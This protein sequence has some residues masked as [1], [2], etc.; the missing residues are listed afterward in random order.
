MTLFTH[1]FIRPIGPAARLGGPAAGTG[2]FGEALAVT[3]LAGGGFAIAWAHRPEGGAQGIWMRV[4]GEDGTPEGP[5]RQI[6]R[7]LTDPGGTPL[8][9]NA[10]HITP[11]EDGFLVSWT[12]VEYN[13]GYNTGRN[14]MARLFD[15]DGG[16]QTPTFVAALETNAQGD[17]VTSSWEYAPA[18]TTLSDGR[19]VLAFADDGDIGLKILSAT[20]TSLTPIWRANAVAEGQQAAPDVAALGT[21][22]FVVV[23]EDSSSSDGSDYGVFAQVFDADGER[24]GTQFVVSS[25]TFASQYAPQVA[26]LAG[27]AFVV[28]WTENYDPALETNRNFLNARIFDADGTPRG[29]A[30]EI[31]PEG[32]PWFGEDGAEIV[33]LPDGGFLALYTLDTAKPGNIYGDQDVLI[34]RFDARGHALGPEFRVNPGDGSLNDGDQYQLHGTALNDGHVALVWTNAA[35]AQVL[36]RLIDLS[37]VNGTGTAGDDFITLRGIGRNRSLGA[38]DDALVGAGGNDS[39]SGGGGND[40][41][42]GQGGADQISG[43]DG[44][45]RIEGGTGRDHLDGGRGNDRLGGDAGADTLSGGGGADVFLFAAATDSGTGANRD[46]ITD[47][48]TGADQID[49]RALGLIFID[50]TPFSGSAGELRFARAGDEGLLQADLDGDGTA[51]FV[52]RLANVTS[53]NADDLLL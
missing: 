34:R 44:A 37:E 48:G 10:P 14:V 12:S 52:L 33:A 20:G 1:D 53:L 6:S 8:D 21:G 49:L 31:R 38:G 29:D 27:G 46:L 42:A 43:E 7:A 30:F 45:D 5:A 22:G 3:A 15:A 35:T 36:T 9:Q 2:F 18:S 28:T 23:W 26:R 32:G 39:V 24:V 25:E 4:F 13:Y 17:V 41:I 16:A 51:D 47:F 11:A 50:K 19:I 40:S